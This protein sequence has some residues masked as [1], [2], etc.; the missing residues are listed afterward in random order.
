MSLKVECQ[1]EELAEALQLASTASRSNSPKFALK[2][3]RLGAESGLITVLGCDGE[4]W[5]ERDLACEV[6]ESGG[7]LVDAKFIT[8]LV[9]AMPSGQVALELLVEDGMRVQQG[10]AEYKVLSSD[11]QDF[12]EPPDF[13]GEGELTLKFSQLQ[14]ALDSVLYAVTTDPHRAILTGVQVSYDGA[15]LKLV[16]TDTHRLAVRTIAQEGM[17]SSLSVVIPDRALR[18][19]RSLPVGAD[20]DVTIRFGMGRLGVEA[21]GARVVAQMLSGAYPNWERVVPSEF[22]RTWQVERD[23]LID[24]LKRAMIIA[25]E[26]ANRV[27]FSGSGDSLV[28]TAKSE[29]LGEAKEEIPMIADNGQ[30]E[31][32]FNGRYVL[33]CIQQI[34]GPGIRFELTE[35]TRPG[36]IRPAEDGDDYFCVIMP[37]SLT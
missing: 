36:V 10:S 35:S 12:P 19:I 5:V 16:A 23:Q 14:D 9:S 3:L 13:G 32:A 6:I 24:S 33:D 8:S 30:I 17:G 37:M 1:K 29:E 4:M 15:T 28:L 20:D 31:V 25:S 11:P 21:G 7:V 26:S 2:S 22:S 18:A 34:K 27:K